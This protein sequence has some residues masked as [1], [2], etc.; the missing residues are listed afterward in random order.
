MGI[1]D[2]FRRRENRVISKAELMTEKG[3][4]YYSWNGSVY[5]SDIVRA[6]MRPKVKAVGKLVGKHIRETIMEDGRREIAINPSFNMRMLLEE[7]N[8]LMSGQV[9][10]EKMA[11][12]LIM[13]GNAFALI[14][15]NP[16]GIPV[17]LYPISPTNVE[18][19]YSR[20]GDLS[21]KF[22]MPNHRTFTFSY[23]DI[24]HLRTDFNEN[25]IFGTPL[26][27]ALVPLLN[28]VTT[29]DQG[30]INAIKNSSVIRW[31]LTFSNTLRPDDLKKQAKEF[32]ENYLAT[33][34]SIGVAAVD[35]KTSA[36]QVL[37]KDYVPNATQMDRTQLRIL[38]LFNISEAMICGTATEEERNAYF[39]AE[40]EPIEIQMGDEYTRKLFTRRQR[41]FGNKII[42]EESAWSSASMKTKLNLLQMVDRGALTPNEWRA[43]FN[44]AP[45]Q[46]GDQPI[47]RLDTAIVTEGNTA[48]EGGRD[49]ED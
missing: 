4:G 48:E 12:Q 16:D 28:V 37:P 43:A 1:F 13:N 46:G 19:I 23:E 17:A 22:T 38:R 40:I 2:R 30:I 24:I 21:I 33:E 41:G 9:L 3:N 44:L 7:P 27:P 25:D 11:A 20:S 39:D 34:S 42:F 32:A 36:T 10:Q 8:P 15:R 45:V 6:C 29:T 18:A 31:L 35:A 14:S 47:R 5:Q 49:D 26:A